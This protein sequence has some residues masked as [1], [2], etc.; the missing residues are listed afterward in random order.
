MKNKIKD[1]DSQICATVTCRANQGEINAIIDLIRPTHG[2]IRLQVEGS[3]FFV[4]GSIGVN[5][6]Y[7]QRQD[8]LATNVDWAIELGPSL[9]SPLTPGGISVTG[10]PLLGWWSADLED[11]VTG[12]YG[13][14]SGTIAGK[15]ALSGALTSPLKTDEQYGQ[16]P[17]TG[18]FGGGAGCCYAGGGGSL[19]S[20]FKYNGNWIFD[21]F[22]F[23]LPWHW[24]FDK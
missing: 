6:L 5:F 18:Y 14:L 15:W 24:S 21:D 8:R 17:V 2:G 13:M 11:F 16:I 19:G 12:G 7:N 9:I 10:G 1:K 3:V 4:S 22:S 20:T 23:L